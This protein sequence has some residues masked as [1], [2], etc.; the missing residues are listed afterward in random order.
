MTMARRKTT[1]W[2]LVGIGILL[3]VAANWH[4]VHVASTSQ[5]D[6]VAHLRPGEEKGNQGQFRAA[7]S[8]C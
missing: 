2:M 8:A 1:I 5:P 6:C 3:V 7:G 4:L